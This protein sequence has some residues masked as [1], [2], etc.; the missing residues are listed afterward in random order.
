MKDAD[1]KIGMKV[2]PFQKTTRTIIASLSDSVM[3][4]TA[5]EHDQPFLYVVRFR[6]YFWVLSTQKGNQA[7][8]DWFNACDFRPY[9]PNVPYQKS[10][11]DP[12]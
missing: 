11:L 2:V 4:R 8:G 7:S 12:D 10:L 5:K 6:E 1:V 3:W 9:E